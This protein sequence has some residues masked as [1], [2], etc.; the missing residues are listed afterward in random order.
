[1]KPSVKH[2]GASRL[3]PL[4][5]RGVTTAWCP[6]IPFGLVLI[7]LIWFRYQ[8]VLGI[9]LL[10]KP[11]EEIFVVTSAKLASLSVREKLTKNHQGFLSTFPPV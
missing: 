8:N 3:E 1:M 9:R 7:Y 6:L 4:T 2:S 10:I 11:M 5:H